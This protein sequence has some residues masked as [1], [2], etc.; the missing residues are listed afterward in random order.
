MLLYYFFSTILLLYY[1]VTILLFYYYIITILL[2]YYIITLLLYYYYVTILL[3]YFYIITLLLYF[4]SIIYHYII[5]IL[6]LYYYTTKERSSSTIRQCFISLSIQYNTI[7]VQ[8]SDTPSAKFD[9]M[10]FPFLVH[11]FIASDCFDSHKTLLQLNYIWKAPFKLIAV[12]FF[13]Q[14]VTGISAFLHIR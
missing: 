13:Q 11:I 14:N 10:L 9:Y 1:Y 8:S 2:Y 4:Y 7:L 6:L 5:T 3:V 12:T